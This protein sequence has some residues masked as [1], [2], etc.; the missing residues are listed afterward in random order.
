ML[1]LRAA[2]FCPAAAAVVAAAAAA[3]VLQVPGPRWQLQNTLS[4]SE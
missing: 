2:P 3:D 4:T 1:L